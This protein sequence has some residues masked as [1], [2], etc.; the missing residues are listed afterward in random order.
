[1]ILAILLNMVKQ[2]ILNIKCTKLYFFKL[3]CLEPF[4]LTK[5]LLFVYLLWKS[6]FPALSG[7]NLPNSKSSADIVSIMEDYC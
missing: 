4:G 1:M 7:F 6:G 5:L 2:Y 3:D